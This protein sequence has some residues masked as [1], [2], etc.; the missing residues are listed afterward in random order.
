MRAFRLFSRPLA[1]CRHGCSLGSQVAKGV[2]VIPPFF[3]RQGDGG[4]VST[5][6]E[7][8]HGRGEFRGG[9]ESAGEEPAQERHEGEQQHEDVV[10]VFSLF[11]EA[12]AG[13]DVFG[14]STEVGESEQGGSHEGQDSDDEHVLQGCALSDPVRVGHGHERRQGEHLS[15]YASVSFRVSQVLP[16]A[17]RRTSLPFSRVASTHPLH[18]EAP[19]LPGPS[20]VSVQSRHGGFEVDEMRRDGPSE[21]TSWSSPFA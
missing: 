18:H 19:E 4:T 3:D 21:W 16:R 1:S 5:A 12:L 11:V 10:D 20:H 17:F 8:D 2:F 7:Q 13:P 15:V 14:V 9:V 6:Q